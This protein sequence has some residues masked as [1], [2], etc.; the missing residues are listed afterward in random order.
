MD[1]DQRTV[2]AAYAKAG[3]TVG[4]LQASSAI[5]V[6][7]D[8]YSDSERRAA[9][10]QL[11]AF[12][13]DRY[14]HQTFQGRAAFGRQVDGRATSGELVSDLPL[15]LAVVSHSGRLPTEPWRIHFHV[16]IDIDRFGLLETTR[17]DLLA[18]LAALPDHPIPHL[19]VE[20]YAWS[21]L[22][23]ALR[24]PSLAAGIASELRWFHAQ[25]AR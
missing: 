19:E 15:A 24:A 3:L 10:D 20:T 21:V 9:L 1:E 23:P 25:L 18:C 5:R 13:E 4:K 16:P 7:F 6:P 8:R 14:L 2:L 22:P 11:A 17:D 12:A